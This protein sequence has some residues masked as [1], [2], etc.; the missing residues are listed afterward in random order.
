MNRREWLFP[1]F[2]YRE[3]KLDYEIIALMW[4][5]DMHNMHPYDI[6]YHKDNQE[7]IDFNMPLVDS[8]IAFVVTARAHD[9]IETY[10]EAFLD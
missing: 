6:L 7:Q 9:N 8:N 2:K 4:D 3:T 10:I 1:I 5:H